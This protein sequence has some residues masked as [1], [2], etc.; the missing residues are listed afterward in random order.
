MAGAF[1][2]SLDFELY[3]GVRDSKSLETYKA[4]ILGVREAMS[5]ML[6]VFK[7]YQVK[8]TVATVGLLFFD[9][10]DS[11]TKAIPSSLPVYTNSQY[12]WF[13]E[14]LVHVGENEKEDP[15][16]F[17]KSLIESIQ[18]AGIHEI[19]THTFSHYYTLEEGADEKSFREDLKA[20]R[21]CAQQA[22]LPFNTI[23]FPRNQ[24]NRSILEI[25]K[26]EGLKVS[27]VLK[28]AVYTNLKAEY[29]KIN[30][31]AWAVY[32]IRM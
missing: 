11:L 31:V 26:E 27:E 8:A 30:S 21:L 15:L 5:E 23:I 13:P 9:Q 25:C 19:A 18:K 3:W 29:M 28:K 10:K 7:E 17:G 32:W 6:N 20:A 2:L 1:V 24:Y 16:H 4:N 14:Y 12:N 22:G